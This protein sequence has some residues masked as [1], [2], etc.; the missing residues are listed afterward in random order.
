M[1][2]SKTKKERREIGTS[3]VVFLELGVESAMYDNLENGK[4]TR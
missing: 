1:N 4:M 2:A 3:S